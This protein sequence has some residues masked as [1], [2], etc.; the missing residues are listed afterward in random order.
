MVQYGR[1]QIF[2]SPEAGEEGQPRLVV[3]T[4]PAQPQV[5]SAELTERHPQMCA[6]GQP[7]GQLPLSIV[8]SLGLLASPNGELSK[9]LH[10]RALL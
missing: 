9:G 10:T 8:P 6:T 3:S 4:V 2:R 5:A 1:F 7:D